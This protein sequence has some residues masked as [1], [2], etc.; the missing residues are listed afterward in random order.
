MCT[1]YCKNPIA[2]VPP[3]FEVKFG[4]GYKEIPHAQPSYRL[5]HLSRTSVP[6]ISRTALIPDSAPFFPPAN[7]HNPDS[8]PVFPPSDLNPNADPFVPTPPPQSANLDPT[9]CK[10]IS[11]FIACTESPLPHIPLQKYP[12][13]STQD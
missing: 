3:E 1:C 11:P 5:K 4:T 10:S 12:I 2:T 9:L 13:L 7:K 6:V 8:A